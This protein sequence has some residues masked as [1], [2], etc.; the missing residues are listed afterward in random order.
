MI[1]P[2]LLALLTVVG[3]SQP[4]PVADPHA[5]DPDRTRRIVADCGRGFARPDCETARAR[6]A[7]AR[8]S[9]RMA[10]YAET[11]EDSGS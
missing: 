9:R 7:E 5:A 1:R 2:A 4:E 10:A 8:R 6:A 11:I 3:C